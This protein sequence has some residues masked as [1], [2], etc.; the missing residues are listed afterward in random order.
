MSRPT[1]GSI[2]LRGELDRPMDRL[3]RP[4]SRNEDAEQFTSRVHCNFDM[5][6][7]GKSIL[8]IEISDKKAS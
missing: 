4:K 1:Y 3:G 7:R 8:V 6:R 5:N 2:A